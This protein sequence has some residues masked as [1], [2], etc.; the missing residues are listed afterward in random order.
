MGRS[1]TGHRKF[2]SASDIV[3]QDI[4]KDEI[5]SHDSQQGIVRTV[6]VSM[7]WKVDSRRDTDR[8][9]ENIV[10]RAIAASERR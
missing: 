10:P 4:D 2:G 6:E 1:R 8:G 7:D 9:R 3:L 5:A